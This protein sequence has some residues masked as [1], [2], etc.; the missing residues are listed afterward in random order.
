MFSSASY[1]NQCKEADIYS[2]S[3]KM[4]F[5]STSE[6]NKLYKAFAGGEGKNA[7]FQSFVENAADNDSKLCITTDAVRD[8]LENSHDK[9]YDYLLECD[10]YDFNVFGE[11]YIQRINFLRK[12]L[13]AKEITLE[14]IKDDRSS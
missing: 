11:D 2:A 5:I 7:D 13:G 1:S 8:F 10:D 4:K 6:L 14:H 3:I 12:L 9:Y